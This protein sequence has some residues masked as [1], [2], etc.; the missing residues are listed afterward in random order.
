[1]TSPSPIAIT[2]AVA[3]TPHGP[4]TLEEAMLEAPRAGEVRV[5]IVGGGVCHTDLVARD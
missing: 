1:M 2:A 4:F 3:R 5:R